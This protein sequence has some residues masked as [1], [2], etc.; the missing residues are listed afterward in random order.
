MAADRHHTINAFQSLNDTKNLMHYIRLLRPPSLERNNNLKLIITITTD[1]GD[2]FLQA[3]QP[4]PITVHARHLE[5]EGPHWTKHTVRI[6]DGSLKWR[7]GLRVLKLDLRIPDPV[8]RKLRVGEDENS[9]PSI[10]IIASPNNSELPDIAEIPF[11]TEGRILGLSVPLPR[12]EK[13]TCFTAT[14]EFSTLIN[15]VERTLS[16]DEEIGESIDRHV[17]DAGV[18]TT[19]LLSDICKPANEG[20]WRET[21]LLRGILSSANPERPLNVIELGCGVGILGIGLAAALSPQYES[22]AQNTSFHEEG[23]DHSENGTLNSPTNTV[24][25]SGD[26][27][28]IL[29]TDLPDAEELTKKNIIQYREGQW[30]I[31]SRKSPLEFESLDWEDGKNGVFGP[32]ANATEWGLIIISD[33]T[34][35]VDML[36]ALVETLSALHRSSVS[37]AKAG[38]KVMLATKP[39]HSSEKALFELM[40]ASGWNIQESA[41]QPLPSLGLEDE[42]VEIYLFGK[43]LEQ[44]NVARSPHFSTA[45]RRKMA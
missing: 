45:K 2:S 19:G 39:R 25:K 26:F 22:E 8:L 30:E 3:E 28:S 4:L 27:G 31:G 34:Y 38:P 11:D 23:D 32:K 10:R 9:A 24:C 21:P 7:S 35:N 42:R 36:P 5:R 44:D 40:A 41:S 13:E 14:R 18:V 15:G 12:P 20:K 33:C 37:L 6:D 43:D 16:I 1:L 17:W 29:L